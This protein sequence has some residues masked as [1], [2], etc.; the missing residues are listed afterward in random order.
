MTPTF[1]AFSFVD[2]CDPD[3]RAQLVKLWEEIKVLLGVPP[4]PLPPI[5]GRF[6][7]MCQAPPTVIRSLWL[8]PQYEVE[9]KRTA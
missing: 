3:E 7:G 9:I 8:P 1:Y 6:F 5:S 2:L 4:E